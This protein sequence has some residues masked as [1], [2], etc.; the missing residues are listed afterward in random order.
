M[1]KQL[2]DYLSYTPYQLYKS[3]R[4]DL[5]KAIGRVPPSILGTGTP[6]ATKYL[7]GDGTWSP[8]V[9]ATQFKLSALNI[10]PA[11]SIAPGVL[12]EIRITSTHIYVCTATNTWVRSALTTW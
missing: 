1:S 8:I 4:Q 3:T 7:K 10:A 12:G 5:L 9:E 11:S 6:D 2:S